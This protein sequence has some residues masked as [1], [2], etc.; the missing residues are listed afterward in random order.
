LNAVEE[1]LDAMI[2]HSEV[3]DTI[4]RFRS[5]LDQTRAGSC[6]SDLDYEVILKVKQ[7]RGGD[8]LQGHRLGV[9]VR[10]LPIRYTGGD[11]LH[12]REYALCILLGVDGRKRR[13]SLLLS[14][15]VFITVVL[16]V[17]A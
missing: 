8:S 11:L 15:H 12:G 14:G 5:H 13:I 17:S 7:V 6:G 1:H 10:N 4:A 3:A 9:A 2:I 16:H